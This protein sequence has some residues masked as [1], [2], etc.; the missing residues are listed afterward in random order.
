MKKLG[1]FFMILFPLTGFGQL[2]EDFSDGD[3]TANPVWTGLTS[4]FKINA[5]YQLQSQA[6]TSSVSWLF[7][8]S[9]VVENATWECWIKVT[10]STSASNYAAFYLISDKN[11]LSNGCKGYYVQVGGTNDEVALYVQDGTKKTKLIDGA[12]KRTDGNSVE[13]SVRVTRDAQGIFSLYSKKAGETAFVLE[14]SVQHQLFNT[15][16]YTGVLYANTSTTGADYYFDDV[17]VMGEAHKDTEV[18]TLQTALLSAANSIRLDF[19]EAMNWTNATYAIS[20]N[21]KTLS[22]QIISMDKKSVELYFDSDFEHGKQYELCVSGMTDVAG[23]KLADTC[24]SIGFIDRM[25]PGDVV[26]NEIMCENPEQSAEYVEFYNKSN[27][28]VDLKDCVLGVL[29]SDSSWSKIAHF[30]NKTIFFPNTY[31]AISLYPDSVLRYH[32][33]PDT[34]R[35]LKTEW[36]SLNNENATIA[37][38]NHSCDT[39]YDAVSYRSSWHHV[40]VKNPKGVSLERIHPSMPSNDASSWHS[41]SSASHYGTPGYQN[42]QYREIAAEGMKNIEIK[43]DPEAFTPDNDGVD[44]ICFIRYKVNEPG[45]VA[46]VRILTVDGNNLCQLASNQLLGTEG[47]LS[48]DGKTTKGTNVNPGIYIIYFELFNPDTGDK[49]TFKKPVVVTLR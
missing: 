25:Y 45:Y 13:I 23:N 7:T 4:N 38:L 21:Q 8:P 30:P 46:N 41:A 11:D 29:R 2:R 31:L 18:P 36:T 49:R 14:G 9:E 42:S 28:T 19:S 48:W 43:A 34:A 47:Y 32:A 39:I 10:Y 35:V 27:F 5:A 1:L 44:D 24:L 15:S 6:A 22:S 20:E 33:C 3:F 16:S 12:D 17:S 40:L 37:L 26:I